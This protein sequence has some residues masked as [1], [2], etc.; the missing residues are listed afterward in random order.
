M[1]TL[2]KPNGSTTE[3]KPQNDRNFTLKEL[4]AM[5]D[6]SM[7]QISEAEE[8]GKILIFDE[9][10][11]CRGDLVKGRNGDILKTERNEHGQ[12]VYVSYL[13]REATKRM[14]EYMGPF[15]HNIICGNALLCKDKEL[16]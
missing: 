5:L 7:V 14:A 3:V 16:Q 6:C 9:E 2:I 1:A 8:K 12:T 11:L 15:T 10:F 13:N 4:Y